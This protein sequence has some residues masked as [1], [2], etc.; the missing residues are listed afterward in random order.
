[1]LVLGDETELERVLLAE[2]AVHVHR[3]IALE[4]EA[5]PHVGVPQIERSGE[6]A[7]VPVQKV[8]LVERQARPVISVAWR[9]AVRRFYSR[10]AGPISVDV[11]PVLDPLR[12]R[13][14]VDARVAVAD[15][16]LDREIWTDRILPLHGVGRTSLLV[17]V[18]GFDGGVAPHPK[19]ADPEGVRRV[20]EVDLVSRR[21]LP[22]DL[23]KVPPDVVGP[24]EGP[25]AGQ[26]E[27]NADI[28]VFVVDGEEE[29]VADDLPREADG[30]LIPVEIEELRRQR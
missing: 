2:K 8:I 3:G 22:G 28:V 18:A 23:V 11:R 1:M 4:R 25:P 9:G 13:K 15:D 12:E 20:L 5:L 17:A 29:L 26:H 21:S 30:G 16:R 6:S 19:R 14:E 7:I 24:D 10:P 27:R